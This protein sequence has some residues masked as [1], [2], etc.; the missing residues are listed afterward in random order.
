ML[1]RS[2]FGLR[3]GWHEWNVYVSRLFNRVLLCLQGRWCLLLLAVFTSFPCPNSTSSY[4]PIPFLISSLQIFIYPLFM[5]STPVMWRCSRSPVM[6][7]RTSLVNEIIRG[8][9][10]VIW[11]KSTA[12][13]I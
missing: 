2:R 12:G 10:T 6:H 1:Y 8:C 4:F 13:D 11:V 5:Q 9:R 3:T 7:V